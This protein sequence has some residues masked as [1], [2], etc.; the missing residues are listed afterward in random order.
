MEPSAVFSGM[1]LSV[2]DLAQAREAGRPH[3]V[4]DVREFGEV[5][6]CA[7]PDSMHIPMGRV[8]EHLDYLPRDRP[9]FVLC[10]HG[11]R[12]FAVVDYL[13]R[14]GLDNVFNLEGGIDAWAREI[15]ASV[16]LY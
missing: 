3:A 10:H 2:Q 11:V 15:D 16:A 5:E 7:L 14:N 13:R 6:I 8:P 1:S 4:L 12:S 9:V